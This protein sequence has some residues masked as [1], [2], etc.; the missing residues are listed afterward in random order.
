MRRVGKVG[1]TQPSIALGVSIALLLTGSVVA[2]SS[3]TARA[4]AVNSSACFRV[5]YVTGSFQP[6]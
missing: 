2:S 6:R 1:L 4:W 5:R 3:T